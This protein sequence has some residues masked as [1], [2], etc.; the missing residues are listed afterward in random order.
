MHNNFNFSIQTYLRIMRS[1]TAQKII[2]RCILFLFNFFL[3]LRQGHSFNLCN[4]D[5]RS[6]ILILG[7]LIKK[8]PFGN[9]S[10][11]IPLCVS[12]FS[13]E[14]VIKQSV[15]QL[16]T[17]NIIRVYGYQGHLLHI[18]KSLLRPAYALLI[19]LAVMRQ[20]ISRLA[21]PAKT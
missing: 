5:K 15:E 2:Q 21:G 20:D 11:F 14:H 8:I 9:F 16:Q 17:L 4:P 19:P 6:Q 3:N 10:I 1:H 13:G 7:C 18:L 12:L